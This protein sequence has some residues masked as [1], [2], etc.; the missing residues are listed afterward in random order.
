MLLIFQ[1]LPD[2]AVAA[3]RWL[4][5]PLRLSQMASLL[6]VFERPLWW[7]VLRYNGFLLWVLVDHTVAVGGGCWL[8]RSAQPLLGR[9]KT[10]QTEAPAAPSDRSMCPRAA[11]GCFMS[12]KVGGVT[13]G[14]PYPAT[15]PQDCSV[16]LA[17]QLYSCSTTGV[18]R[19]LRCLPEQLSVWN[20]FV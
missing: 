3:L 17:R 11:R 15:V 13:W 16:F 4:W 8:A 14:N 5:S 7:R 6:G 2:F 12:R 18:P 19:L 1:S 10:L 9:S 20:W